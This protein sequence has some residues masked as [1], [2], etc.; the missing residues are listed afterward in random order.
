MNLPDYDFHSLTG[1]HPKRYTVHANGLWCITF[2]FEK[3]MPTKS[4]LSNIT[5]EKSQWL[6]TKQFEILIAALPIQVR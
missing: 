4:I 3:A 2:E 1:F 6:S 5:D